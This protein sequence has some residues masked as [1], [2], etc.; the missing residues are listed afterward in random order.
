MTVYRTGFPIAGTPFSTDDEKR[1]Y[2]TT[3]DALHL[4]ITDMV[5]LFQITQIILSLFLT[6]QVPNKLSWLFLPGVD[7]FSRFCGA[8]NFDSLARKYWSVSIGSKGFYNI[9]WFQQRSIHKRYFA[10]YNLKMDEVCLSQLIKKCARLKNN[11]GGIYP[12]DKFPVLLLNETFVVANSESSKS[13]GRRWVVWSNV[14]G[15]YNFADP[16]CLSLFSH[17]QNIAK[18]ISVVQVEQILKNESPL[19]GQNSHFCGFYWIH[20]AHFLF[21]F[22]YPNFSHITE[23]GLLRFVQQLK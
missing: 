19:Q 22:Y 11:F 12:A 14:K 5:S 13:I 23:T 7:Y 3:M 20:F 4:V 16:L 15:M 9:F 6:L 21:S 2:M 17:Y 1:V 10:P 8:E 18:K